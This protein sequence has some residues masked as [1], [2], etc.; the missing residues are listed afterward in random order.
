MTSVLSFI[1]PGK[2]FDFRDNKEVVRSANGTYSTVS[3][4]NR[5]LSYLYSKFSLCVTVWRSLTP[6]LYFVASKPGV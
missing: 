5:A 3:R 1:F 2:G 4:T 6:I